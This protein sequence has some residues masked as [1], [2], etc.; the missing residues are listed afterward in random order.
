[1]LLHEVYSVAWFHERPPARQKYHSHFH[2][3]TAELAAIAKAARPRQLVLYHQ[4]FRQTDDVD[5][6]LLDEM[7]KAGNTAEVFSAHDLDV[8]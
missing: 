8:F 5:A 2:T 1:L 7:K 4:L 6:V 3:S